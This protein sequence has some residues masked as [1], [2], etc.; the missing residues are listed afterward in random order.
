MSEWFFRFWDNHG[1]RMV[2][3]VL[4]T[5]FGIAFYFAPDLQKEGQTI[6]IMIAGILVNK[7][8]GPM[9]RRDDDK[10]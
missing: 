10:Q 7:V 6:L 2:F 3:M 9:E 4:A 1:E 5:G 8:R